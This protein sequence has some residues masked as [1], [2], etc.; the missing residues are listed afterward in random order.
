MKVLIV[1]GTGCLSSA[2]TEEAIRKGIEVTLINRG[3]RKHLIPKGVRLIQSDKDNFAKIGKELNGEHFDAV[4]DYLCYSDYEVARSFNFY[5]KHTDQ[6][7]FISSCAVYD[8]RCNCES[9]EDSPKVN[10]VWDYSVSKWASEQM[11]REIAS[12]SNTKITI[13]RP[14][15]TYGDTRIPY[16]IS[17]MYGYHWTLVARMLAGKPIITWNNGQNRCNMTR[18]EDFAVGVVGLI[19]NPK[20]YGE[21]FNVCGEDAPTFKEVLDAVSDYVGKTYKTV[22]IPSA[23]YACELPMRAG[24]ILGGRSV[25]AVNTNR[26]LQ[27]AVP[28]FTQKYKIKTGVAITLAAYEKENYQRGIDWQFDGDCDRIIRKW[29]LKNKISTKDMNL[30]FIDYL[31]NATT[32][33]KRLY[34]KA[35]HINKIYYRVR[36]V[37]SKIKILVNKYKI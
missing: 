31:G 15:V 32:K 26:K 36:I 25:D 13:I 12:S 16:G 11:L 1:G 29:C 24:E 20:A 35:S 37:L 22:D 6:Y 4:M 30:G 14:G 23:F 27:N 18:V 17:P 10:P 2:V 34:W 28:Y 21:A 8:T 5:S 33:D 19:G 7:F 9:R 3:N